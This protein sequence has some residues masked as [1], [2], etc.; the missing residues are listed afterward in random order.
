MFH[1]NTEA[2]R[3]FT[4]DIPYE[5][6]IPIVGRIADMPYRS[7]VCI[8]QINAVIQGE[9][10]EARVFLTYRMFLYD[11]KKISLLSGIRKAESE[12]EENN[13][14]VMAIYF[15][16]ENENVWE[17]G[18]RYQVS[19]NSLREINELTMDEL[20]SGQRLLVVKEMR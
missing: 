9:G 16:K 17:V 12:T 4:M 10:I 2:Y 19:L 8:D 11:N 7:H 13:F 5:H 20:Q 6:N 18:K 15:A 3:C 1:T 14:P